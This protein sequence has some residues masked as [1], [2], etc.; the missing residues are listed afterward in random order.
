MT[1]TAQRSLGVPARHAERRAAGRTYENKY[2]LIF[3]LPDWCR[4]YALH[5]LAS[6]TYFMFFA[7]RAFEDDDFVAVIEQSPNTAD[8]RA[9]PPGPSLVTVHMEPTF[10]DLQ[11]ETLP[12]PDIHCVTVENYPEPILD[13]KV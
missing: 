3:F 5:L 9:R 6:N 4:S 12:A 2:A 11:V 8:T 10:Q 1:L 7:K 13:T